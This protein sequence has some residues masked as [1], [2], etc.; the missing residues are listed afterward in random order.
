MSSGREHSIGDQRRPTR[1]LSEFI[2]E[3]EAEILLEW[4]R[5]V[6]H[7]LP[8]AG[9]LQQ[10]ALLDRVPDL[11]AQIAQMADE[12]AAGEPP[13]LPR[14]V[15]EQHA[16]DR[17]QDGFD[18]S[19]VLVEFALLRDCIIGLWERDQQLSPEQ[20]ADLRL[21]NQAI[22]RAVSESV[23]RYTQA[24]DR[25]LAALDRIANAALE[26]K[27]LDDLLGRLLQVLL[28]TTPAVD[29]A[30][31]LLREGDRLRVRAAVGLDDEV[32][33]KF[34]VAVGE[35]FAGSIAAE[36]GPKALSCA[37]T[38]P[39]VKSSV[40]RDRGVRALY[41]LPLVDVDAG[42][43]IGV[44]HIGSL[45]AQQFSDQDK[46]L[47]AAM[48]SRA[49]TAISQ[50]ML[51][52][53]AQANA[54]EAERALAVVDALLSSAL[55]GFA[56]VDTELRYA[57]INN[58]L[59]A[60]NGRSVDDHI[61]RTVRDVLG[62]SADVLEPLL[63][64]VVETGE[65]VANLE[66]TAP[67][68]ATPGVERSF[69]ASY[70]P[71]RAA[72]GQML[73]VGAA[74]VEITDRK[75][76]EAALRLS[77]ARLQSILENAP[78][79]IFIKDGEGRCIVGNTRL[80]QIL[81]RS[82]PEIQG[83]SDHELFPSELADEIRANDRSVLET[84]HSVVA[85][86]IIPQPDGPH[87]FLAIKFPVPGPEGQIFLGGISTDITDRKRF[88][89][90]VKRSEARFR[91]LADTVP[92]LVWVARGDGA[93]E[94]FNQRWYEFTGLTPEQS[95]GTGWVRVLHPEDAPRVLSAWEAARTQGVAYEVECRYRRADGVYRWMLARA[96]PQRDE[97]QA[98][99]QWFG[100]STDITERKRVEE[101]QQFLQNATTALTS[102]LDFRETSVTI[103]KLA[104]PA[105]ADWAIVDFATEDGG[106]ELVAAEHVDRSRA[107]LLRE[108]RRRYPPSPD[109]P[110]GLAHVLRTGQAELFEQIP[111][112]V[113]VQAAKDS[114]HLA[115]LRSLGLRSAIIVPMLAHGR[116]VG[117]I[118]L[119]S[120]ESGR[121]YTQRDLD[122]VQELAARAALALANARLFRE[123]RDAARA[124]EETLA[125]VSHDL[126]NP[127]GAI[128]M[129]SALLMRKPS[130]DSRMCKQLE[131]IRRS[132][133][134][135]DHL[136]SD[137]LDMASIQAGRLGIERRPEYADS[138]IA[139]ILDAHEP[140][141]KEKGL[142]IARRWE[143]DDHRLWCDRDRVM[144]VFGNLLGNAIK[145]CRSGDVITVA[146]E[147]VGREAQFE[148][149]DTGPGISENE[150]PHIFEPYWSAAQHAKQGT[151]L[152]LYISKGIVE[153]H[154]GR[155]WIGA[156]PGG[157]AVF[158]FTLPLAPGTEQS[159]P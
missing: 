143:L 70:F 68:P 116:T 87:T 1:R 114:E 54:A 135:M 153:A 7:R 109:A 146:G 159:Q 104:V 138:L 26:S 76:V 51:R 38:D 36:A 147:V 105:L 29:T 9:R 33:T 102:S 158:H 126:K 71:V 124:R 31:I 24:R 40:L 107:E 94:Y 48:A 83:K 69:L 20:V 12:L 11:L 156:T 149:R 122:V 50:H 62:N 117:A 144:Q 125:V 152:G 155:L 103:A 142:Q 90:A 22:D 5:A 66:F 96:R 17:L 92:Q 28:E 35:G 148:V 134:R 53:S 111:D 14:E 21:L 65:P 58:A 47:L 8:I 15:A 133:T 93:L 37:S 4:Q 61:G 39:L 88:E 91:M 151:G 27:G 41:G 19:Q 113:L 72:T 127:L 73:G 89:E 86:E 140:A 25:A 46:R 84:G 137:L 23:D 13:S 101:E 49:T 64:R 110:R 74:V 32:R 59:A 129:A 16:L 132:A 79:A 45:T 85:E 120:A 52:E 3:R 81:G 106:S 119:A 108:V 145:F 139:E 100:T 115:M 154:G 82:L 123:V 34:S 56:L 128:Q 43:V 63:R 80:T 141:A 42:R 60:I 95:Q 121:R 30:A 75:R 99:V 10:P 118:S 131:I 130:S 136:I 157:G 77:E 2:R 44:A 67:P 6:R 78:A 57:R 55:V 97:H 98:V 18:L 112:E 150:L